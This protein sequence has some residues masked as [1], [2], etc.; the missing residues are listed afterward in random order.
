[1]GILEMGRYELLCLKKEDI[2][3]F[4]TPEEVVHMAT[5][6]GAFWTYDYKA[7]EQGRVGRHALLKSELHSDGFFVSKI[8][9]APENIRLII[10]AQMATKIR[11][12]LQ[13]QNMPGCIGGVPDGATKLGEGIG[14]ILGVEILKMEKVDGRISLVSTV[15]PEKSILLVEDF[16][17]RGT[18]LNETVRLI[19]V[20]QP[21]SRFVPYEP[22][23]IN[24]GGLKY[25]LVEGVGNFEVL[26]VVNWKVQDWDPNKGCPLCEMG[27]VAIKP[28]ETDENWRLLVSSQLS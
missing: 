10:A 27:S 23:I 5:A 25:V 21:E 17:T 16:C 19:R 1:M 12:V 14:A 7:A 11:E 8:L 9:L 15:S 22:V 18:G 2:N 26:P 13:G 4:L 6:L 3:R 24:R 28:K 20:S